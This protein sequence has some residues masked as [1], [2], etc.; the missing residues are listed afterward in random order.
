[1]KNRHN[2]SYL[3]LIFLLVFSVT[4][5]ADTL[6]EAVSITL[7]SNPRIL[8]AAAQRNKVEQQLLQAKATL[9]PDIDVS[10]GYGREYTNDPSIKHKY[11]TRRD[12]SLTLQQK[13]YDGGKRSSVIDHRSKQL[14][15]AELNLSQQKQQISMEVVELY[16]SLLTA[17]S[18][19]ELFKKNSQR[20]ETFYKKN[21]QKLQAGVVKSESVAMLDESYSRVMSE[22]LATQLQVKE[23][24]SS[25]K[26]VVGIYP[27]ALDF[28]EELALKSFNSVEEALEV[29][30]K[31]RAD[32]QIVIAR[33][34][35][36]EAL[37]RGEEAG[38]LP[39]LN[40]A[41]QGDKI[42]NKEGVA[43]HDHAWSAMLQLKYNLFDGG[44]N[45]AGIAE[46]REQIAVTSANLEQTKRLLEEQVTIAWNRVMVVRE[47]LRY[48]QRQ[49]QATSSR[50][51]KMR[52]DFDIGEVSAIE[53]MQTEDELLVIQSA[54]LEE[55]VASLL[56][57]YRLLAATGTVMQ[58]LAVEN[59][60]EPEANDG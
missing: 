40:F 4:L 36:S 9:L 30:N 21:Q 59:S 43:G 48:Q 52:S 37:L 26:M 47:R 56:A 44:K 27:G 7:E 32:L 14:H 55:K 50:Y 33:L 42:L 11:Y 10:F 35:E 31:N 58:K 28:P 51:R 41:L 45:K 8:A 6:E 60:S 24:E 39:K 34:E 22:L 46:K 23:A 12:Q 57:D 53:L 16:L 29:A 19:L 18:R 49:L 54:V 15:I 17:H 13:L 2:K 1:M 25:Y 3:T 5:S 20:H 38:L